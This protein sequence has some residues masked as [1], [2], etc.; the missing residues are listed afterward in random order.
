MGLKQ[1]LG[2]ASLGQI[3]KMNKQIHAHPI[4][5]NKPILPIRVK[6]L[7]LP[8][9]SFALHELLRRVIKGLLLVVG[10]VGLAVDLLVR[11]HVVRGVVGVRGLVV[12]GLDRVH[13]GLF[14]GNLLVKDVGCL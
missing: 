9:V 13:V 14:A 10:V 12:E 7:Q 3:I 2:N 1:L 6:E 4:N 11:L 8:L 5:H